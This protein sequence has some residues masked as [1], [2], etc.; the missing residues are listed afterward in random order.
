MNIQK[1]KV[2]FKK[3]TIFLI[4]SFFENKSKKCRF[5]LLGRSTACRDKGSIVFQVKIKSNVCSKFQLFIRNIFRVKYF[6]FSAVR[7]WTLL[8]K[9]LLGKVINLYIRPGVHPSLHHIHSLLINSFYIPKCNL[10]QEF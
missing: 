1:L 10:P 8:I 9:C 4:N 6:C 3:F 7:R 5:S 2:I